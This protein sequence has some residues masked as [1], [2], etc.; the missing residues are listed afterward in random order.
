MPIEISVDEGLHVVLECVLV[1]VIA[2]VIYFR[3]HVDLEIL[4]EAR[5]G[6][7]DGFGTRLKRSSLLLAT[8]EAVKEG[9]RRAID[10]HDVEDLRRESSVQTLRHCRV[11][12]E[13]ESHYASHVVQ[14]PVGYSLVA[15]RT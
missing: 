4:E 6:N 1:D 3:H 15:C 8:I 7:L 2:D 12:A 5:L 14:G 10:V 11:V 9:R 13:F